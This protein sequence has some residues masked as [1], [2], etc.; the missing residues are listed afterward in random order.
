MAFQKPK[1]PPQFADLKTILAQSKE[2]DNPLYQVVAQILDRLTQLDLTPGDEV[3]ATKEAVET[4]IAKP[5]V[6]PPVPEEEG[7]HAETHEAIGTDPVTVTTLAGYPGGTTN[8]LR[9]DGTF[10][11]PVG[12]TPGPHAGTHAGGG[13]DPIGIAT[14]GGYPSIA[15]LFLNG[16]GGFTAPVGYQLPGSVPETAIV[17]GTLLARNAANET[18]A[19]TWNF[20]PGVRERGRTVAMGEWQDYTVNWLTISGG[21]SLGGGALVG[22][23]TII[24]KTVIVQ[25]L[26]GFASTTNP[27]TGFWA[28]SL[29]LSVRTPYSTSPIGT[30]WFTNQFAAHFTGHAVHANFMSG[31]FTNYVSAL[32]EVSGA[33]D[34]PLNQA[35]PFTWADNCSC[36]LQFSY[37]IA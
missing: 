16:T 19:G 14:L 23:Y 31:S 22:R 11:V 12:A 3:R 8:F 7:G 13:S 1:K 33:P 20:T 25:I 6:I 15:T 17:D 5:P 34:T 26:L 18:I 29:P 10:N 4:I 37:E 24:G 36:R 21:N 9:A 27:G 32:C 35:T 28:F 2:T 30:A